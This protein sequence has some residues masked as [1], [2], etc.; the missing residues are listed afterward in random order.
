[1]T[2]TASTIVDR[3]RKARAFVHEYFD[4]LGKIPTPQDVERVCVALE[5]AF[6]DG[7]PEASAEEPK[8]ATMIP[9]ISW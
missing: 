6:P 8:W 5:R 3:R 2:Q 4:L 1:M 7:P 9:C